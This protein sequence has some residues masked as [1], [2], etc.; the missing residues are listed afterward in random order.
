MNC[1]RTYYIPVNNNI[2]KGPIYTLYINNNKN[3]DLT[4]ILEENSLTLNN[5]INPF[6]ENKIIL[7]QNDY[8]ELVKLNNNINSVI[9]NLRKNQEE[10]NKNINELIT[11]N[12]KYIELFNNIGNER[13]I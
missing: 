3:L 10:I 7:E 9:N 2:S 1:I 13:K 12:I 8:D 6:K 4:S 11:I 5:M